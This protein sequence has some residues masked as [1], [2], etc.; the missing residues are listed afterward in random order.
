MNL[1]FCSS[2]EESNLS[3]IMVAVRYFNQ[4]FFCLDQTKKAYSI[5][6]ALLEKGADPLKSAEQLLQQ[7]HLQN[8]IIHPFSYLKV[9]TD[10]TSWYGQI[11]IAEVCSESFLESDFLLLDHLPQDLLFPVLQTAIWKKSIKNML[12]LYRQKENGCYPVNFM[13]PKMKNWPKCMPKR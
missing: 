10:H 2:V 6:A 1:E 7:K 9:E 13:L 8:G 4:W 3:F 5:P 11:F 12:I